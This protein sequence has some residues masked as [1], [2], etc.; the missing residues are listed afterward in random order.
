[1]KSKDP[2]PTQ[3]ARRVVTATRQHKKGTTAQ[4]MIDNRPEAATQ[5]KMQGFM[6]GSS[7]LQM[8]GAPE[9]EMMQGKFDV[10][11]HEGAEEEELV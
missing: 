5:R 11:Q 4:H 7:P 8:M 1:M 6:H 3:R 10:Q 2:R 9:E